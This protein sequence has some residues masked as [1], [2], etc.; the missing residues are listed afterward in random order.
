MFRWGL[1]GAG[2]VMCDLRL[3]SHGWT[4]HRAALA[5][6]SL[7]AHLKQVPTLWVTQSCARCRLESG[8]RAGLSPMASQWVP[9]DNLPLTQQ[10]SPSC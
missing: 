5:R 1:G 4:C 9:L 3:Q 10:H 8:A 7:G 6:Q 2:L